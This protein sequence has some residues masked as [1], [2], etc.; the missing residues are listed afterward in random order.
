MKPVFLL[1]A[2][3]FALSFNP[4]CSRRES[5]PA[6]IEAGPTNAVAEAPAETGAEIPV[7]ESTP[8]PAPSKEGIASLCGDENAYIRNNAKQALASWESQDYPRAVTAM[9][10]VLS[11]CRSSAQQDAALSSLAQLTQEVQAA[12]AKSSASAKEAAAL[13]AQ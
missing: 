6:A 12:A 8:V 5:P 4:G 7:P 13:L 10:K 11:L 3:A 2:A 1:L 9:Q